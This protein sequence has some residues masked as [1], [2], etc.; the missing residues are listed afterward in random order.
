LRSVHIGKYLIP[1]WLL[2]ILVSG[3]GVGAYF[4][5]QTLLLS[6]QVLEPLSVKNYPSQLSLYPGETK[7]FNV[8]LFNYAS[9]NYSVTFDYYLSNA[10]YQDNYVTFS[11]N[12]YAV[13]PGQQD[14][15]A[16]LTVKPDAP[17]VTV[18]LTINL[19]RGVYPSGLVGYWA[20]DEINGKIAYDNSGNGNDGLLIGNISRVDGKYGK[21]LWLRQGTAYVLVPDTDTLSFSGAHPFT[22]MAWIKPDIEQGNVGWGPYAANIIDKYSNYGLV[23]DHA[24]TDARGLVIRSSGA[25]YHSG[26]VEISAGTWHHYVGVYDPP[27]LIV[28]LDGSEV[29]RR[30]VGSLNLDTNNNNVAFGTN[31][32]INTMFKGTIDEIKIYDRA[33]TAQEIHS[34]YTNSP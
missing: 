30:E 20:F 31:M 16:W 23:Y 17:P 27:Y 33:L 5:F 18:S 11:H 12:I 8:T 15:T 32:E 24:E 9:I 14:L 22:I 28:Y 19:T 34:E 13:I 7:E 21:A 29:A 6:L 3:V 4:I 26:K 2:L 1:I 10:T 25:W